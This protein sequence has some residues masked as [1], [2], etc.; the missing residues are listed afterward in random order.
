MLIRMIHMCVTEKARTRI[1]IAR[2][3]NPN[4]KCCSH[5]HNHSEHAV[6]EA[7]LTR[8]QQDAFNR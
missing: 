7:T 5:Q 6:R 4:P 2:L 3:P 1:K 8:K